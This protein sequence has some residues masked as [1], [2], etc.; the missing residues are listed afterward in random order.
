MFLIFQFADATLVESGCMPQ[1]VE[2]EAHPDPDTEKNRDCPETEVAVATTSVPTI[3]DTL[4]ASESVPDPTSES[5]I[6]GDLCT[7]SN[8]HA[9]E[10]ENVTNQSSSTS[11]KKSGDEAAS[12][13]AG[14]AELEGGS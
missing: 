14:Q 6:K 1:V 8:G 7:T 11:L 10:L 4:V 3:S 12:V 5:D 9:S 2:N 13:P